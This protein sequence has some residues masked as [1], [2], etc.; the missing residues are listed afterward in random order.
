M[1]TSTELQTILKNLTYLTSSQGYWV[2]TSTSGVEAYFPHAGYREFSGALQMWSRD[3]TQYYTS[4]WTSDQPLSRY[5]AQMVF[6][7]NYQNS[8]QAPFNQ[9]ISRAHSIRCIKE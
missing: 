5:G 6:L 7:W 9:T 4:F 2:Q 1:P 8:A 3:L